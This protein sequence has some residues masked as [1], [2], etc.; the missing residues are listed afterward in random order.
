MAADGRLLN[1]DATELEL[2]RLSQDLQISK[3]TLVRWVDRG[4]IDASL[5]WGISPENEEIRLI[6]VTPRSLDFL[7]QFADE[8]REETVSRT[9]ARHL[10]KM[11]D[12][13]Q[14]QR[15]IRHGE[16]EARKVAD[17]T[18]VV[19]GSVEDYLMELEQP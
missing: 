17:E 7:R 19:V 4:L 5:A 15:L 10:L 8:Y 1:G 2:D 11:V 18:R 9:D 13:S 12:R 3:Q 16:L 6:R 14:V